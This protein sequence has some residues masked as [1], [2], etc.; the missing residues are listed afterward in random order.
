MKNRI[1][2]GLWFLGAF[3][4]F[5]VYAG[6]NPASKAYVDAQFARIQAQI[7][8]IH[9]T[10]TTHTVGECFGGGVVFYV[11]PNANAAPGQRGLIAALTDASSSVDW[12][13]SAPS[14]DLGLGW[15]L[16]TGATNTTSLTPI[17][18]YPAAQSATNYTAS[19]Y[20]DWYLPSEGELNT[21]ILA[22]NLNSALFTHCSGTDIAAGQAYWSSSQV[23]NSSDCNAY[24]PIFV[25]TSD[26][27]VATGP[28]TSFSLFVRSVRAF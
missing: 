8:Q 20:T 24:R 28:A 3:S 2:W 7:D 11:N 10:T 23:G 14:T 22:F 26:G 21:L 25:G 5:A 13:S 12:A 6:V 18:D 16:F 15:L 27:A 9:S 19:G 17:A 1:K 4:V